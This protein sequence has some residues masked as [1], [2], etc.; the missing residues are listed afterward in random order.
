MFAA[1][2]R[3]P[4]PSVQD[5]FALQVATTVVPDYYFDSVRK[6]PCGTTRVL[7]TYIITPIGCSKGS[8][9]P[10]DL[11][12]QRWGSKVGVQRVDGP[13]HAVIGEPA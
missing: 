13:L 4:R 6:Q 10:Q 2:C 3:P 7:V 9:A 1:W 12:F 5:I 11:W 8:T